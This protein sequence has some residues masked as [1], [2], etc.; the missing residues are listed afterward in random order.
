M[1]VSAVP[2]EGAK[3]SSDE[4]DAEEWR[5]YA[6]CLGVDPDLFFPERGASTREAKEVCK[7]CVVRESCLEAALARGE[8]FG[9]W[10]GMSERERRRV[11]RKRAIERAE[12]RAVALQM[13]SELGIDPH[14]N[15]VDTSARRGGRSGSSHRVTE[16]EFDEVIQLRQN[17]LLQRILSAGPDG[18]H[19][20]D[21]HGLQLIL[22]LSEAA[23]E[24][25]FVPLIEAKLV[26]L[27]PS[28]HSFWCRLTALGRER[29]GAPKTPLVKPK[30]QLSQRRSF[31]Q[32]LLAPPT[33]A[34]EKGGDQ[35]KVGPAMA[36]LKDQEDLNGLDQEILQF[37]F[38]AGGELVEKEGASATKPL[39]DAMSTSASYVNNRLK[40]LV[41]ELE[42][43]DWERGPRFINRIW[44][45]DGGRALFEGA[46][47]S[48][49][50]APAESAQPASDGTLFVELD[51]IDVE[52]GLR[53]V[54]ERHEDASQ[55]QAEADRVAEELIEQ[56]AA[57][58]EQ[59]TERNAAL[60]QRVDELEAAEAE[61]QQRLAEIARRRAELEAE[62]AAL[63]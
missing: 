29:V 55:A 5:L 3:T 20:S 19:V 49:A 61:R 44:L 56:L 41:E 28:E 15:D 38:D 37:I 23:Y 63:A 13:M 11:R 31:G 9:I 40:R 22:G 25:Q 42:L 16:G 8:K 1:I 4:L 12:Q 45:T 36:T 24:Q 26:E 52:A 35:G 7:G 50:A 34:P 30:K 43:L 53:T 59:L 60:Q 47:P 33:P 10:G 17:R 51:P 14:A 6:N 46:S 58:V 27:S 48:S 57:R 62:E 39:M 32:Q 21:L 54:R 18:L 2:L